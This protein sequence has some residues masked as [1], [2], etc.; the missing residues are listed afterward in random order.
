MFYLHLDLPNCLV[1]SYF[2]AQMFQ[3]ELI[4][5]VAECKIH[6]VMEPAS[7]KEILQRIIVT[8]EWN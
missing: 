4:K 6:V 2:L 1:L 5:F 3:Q 7:G 8:D